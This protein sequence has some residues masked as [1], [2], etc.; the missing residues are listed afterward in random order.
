M[1]AAQASMPRIIHASFCLILLLCCSGKSARIEQPAPVPRCV[2]KLNP[3]QKTKNK[4]K[5]K[6]VI[7]DRA[8]EQNLILCS[9]S[10]SLFLYEFS[11]ALLVKPHRR[12]AVTLKQTVCLFSHRAF[13][14]YP[15]QQTLFPRVFFYLLWIKE[16][17]QNARMF[18]IRPCAIPSPCFLTATVSR[19]SDEISYQAVIGRS[20][21]TCGA[22][23]LMQSIDRCHMCISSTIAATD[24][25]QFVYREIVWLY[26][27]ISGFWLEMGELLLA[28]AFV[29][30]I[31]AKGSH[32]VKHDPIT[33]VQEDA[34]SKK[35][36]PLYQ[37]TY[38][39]TNIRT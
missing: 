35:T 20:L 26:D 29:A 15:P 32:R 33:T 38:G 7:K 3:I 4:I 9:L 25:G 23:T 34:S 28:I 19:A 36:I 5:S 31:Q 17:L 10:L 1:E 14:I 39:G 22:P 24:R 21:S 12:F 30:A 13:D 18:C 16:W 27:L 11:W 37:H 2:V 6:Q 8:M